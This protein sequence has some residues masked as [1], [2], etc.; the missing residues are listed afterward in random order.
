MTKKSRTILFL[1]CLFLF[2]LVAPLSIFYSQGYRF[3]FDPPAGGK[4]FTQ[5]GGIFLKVRPKQVDIYI[6]GKLK[7][8][9]DFFFGSALVENL[10]PK[11]YKVEVKKEGYFP[12]KKDLEIKE[13]EVTEVKDVILFPENLNLTSLAKVVENFWLSP[14]ERKIILKEANSPI[15]EPPTNGW[16]LKLYDLEKDIK[17]H[18]IKEKDISKK[19]ADL[20]NLSFSENS[21]EI[22]LETGV[23]E[24]IRYFSLGLIETPPTL[25][26][27]RA[28]LPQAENSVVSQTFDGNSYYLDNSG[29]LFKNKDNNNE[30]LTERA[31][32]VKAETEYK[33]NVFPDYIFLREN[34]ILYL[35]SFELKTFEKFFEG[36]QD[37]KI[38]PDQKKIV[39]SSAQE[40]W[41]L[42][43]KENKKVL[44]ARLSEKIENCFW[45]NSNY[46]IFNAGDKIKISETDDRDRINIWDVGEIKKPPQ[47]KPTGQAEMFWNSV[48]KRLYVLS[49]GNLYRSRVLL[50]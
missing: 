17:S 32:P 44:L 34:Q 30:R 7:K 31:F 33:L 21:K 14:D 35:F 18:L 28:P 26:E 29:H 6:D 19:G 36:A 22:S 41:V 23:A 46:L 16:T 27:T 1:I 40:V 50:P 47:D 37:L 2:V 39:Y 3:D 43:L 9:T 4:R 38:S 12:W 8:K 25:K 5:T 15:S 45:L 49:E 13:R 20:L 42:F 10:L 48:E 24:E 11:T